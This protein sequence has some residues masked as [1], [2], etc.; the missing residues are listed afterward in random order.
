MTARKISEEVE[1]EK[2]AAAAVLA[3][4][5]AL[6]GG[7]K[8]AEFYT[9]EAYVP[10][11]T[12]QTEAI[13]ACRSFNAERENLYLWG[14]TGGGK[15]HLSCGVAARALR[16]KKTVEFFKPGTFLRS[17]RMKEPAVQDKL[18]DRYAR[19]EVFVLD[20]LGL[21]NSTDSSLGMFYELLD[22]RDMAGQNGLVVTSN[23]S[24]DGLA[25]ALKDDRLP[26]RLAGLCRVIH[27]EGPDGRMGR[28]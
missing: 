11:T 24:L 19:A 2:T 4:L 16:E 27:I 9:L 20:D 12:S 28:K 13:Q 5:E 22:M 21:G 7:R 14:P 17:L 10:K 1:Q 6:F 8:A 3:G 25:V 15:T 18:F 26:S 23:L